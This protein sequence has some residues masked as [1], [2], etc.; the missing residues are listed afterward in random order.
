MVNRHGSL[1]DM[2]LALLNIKVTFSTSKNRYEMNPGVTTVRD[3]T[4]GKC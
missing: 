3:L 4:E 2:G 1:K